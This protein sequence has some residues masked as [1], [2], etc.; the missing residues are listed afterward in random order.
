ML[1]TTRLQNLNNFQYSNNMYHEHVRWGCGLI[2]CYDTIEE[3]PDMCE[4]R[5]PEEDGRKSEMMTS[6]QMLALAEREEWYVVVGDHNYG[7]CDHWISIPF[8]RWIYERYTKINQ[9]QDEKNKTVG[10]AR[11]NISVCLTK[12]KNFH[13]SEVWN[14]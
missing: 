3:I 6:R 14:S 2:N 8:R 11:S 12:D 9:Y 5:F 13:Y 7:V 4:V 10:Y 1:A